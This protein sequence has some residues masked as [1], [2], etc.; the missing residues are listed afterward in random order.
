LTCIW[1]ISNKNNKDTWE[2]GWGTLSTEEGGKGILPRTVNKQAESGRRGSGGSRVAP[3]NQECESLWEWQRE[4]NSTGKVG[5][6]TSHV[7]YKQTQWLAG[8][9]APP[10][11]Q[12]VKVAVGG[13]LHRRVGKTHFPHEL[14]INMQVRES[15][16]SITSPSVFG[17]GTACSRGSCTGELWV[18][19]VCRA[20]WV[21]SSFLR[22][23]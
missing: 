13:K 19:K 16:C 11:N 14:Y 2:R 17:K 20:R 3:S 12:A 18:N 23:A 9:A 21:L 6:P 8:A 15:G 7:S 4:E 5:R 1:V 10:S 22:S